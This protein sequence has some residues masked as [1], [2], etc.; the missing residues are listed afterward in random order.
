MNNPKPILPPNMDGIVANISQDTIS[1]LGDD[2]LLPYL[3]DDDEIELLEFPILIKEPKWQILGKIIFAIP[4]LTLLCFFITEA[5]IR[6][7]ES[8][9]QL[10]YV[11]FI[12][13]VIFIIFVEYPRQFYF[14]KDNVDFVIHK[15]YFKYRKIH[16]VTGRREKSYTKIQYRDIYSIDCEYIKKGKHSYYATV[17]YFLEYSNDYLFYRKK[18][19]EIRIFKWEKKAKELAVLLRSLMESYHKTHNCKANLPRFNWIKQRKIF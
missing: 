2:M 12:L 9:S 4:L 7:S 13:L 3:F 18:R 17:V 14:L 8:H 5:F 1:I 10:F 16:T 11:P 6:T 19:L 15:S